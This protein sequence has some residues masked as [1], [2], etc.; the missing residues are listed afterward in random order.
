MYNTQASSQDHFLSA[1]DWYRWIAIF[2]LEVGS[3]FFLY[4]SIAVK[5]KNPNELFVYMTLTTVLNIFF[6]YK[7]ISDTVEINKDYI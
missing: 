6:T 4:K 5:E 7:L 2:I 3:V 1:S